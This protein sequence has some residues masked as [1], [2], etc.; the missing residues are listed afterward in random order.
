MEKPIVFTLL[1]A[2]CSIGSLSAQQDTVITLQPGPSNGQDVPLFEHSPN[3]N[4]DQSPEFIS[5]HWNFNN[6]ISSGVSL[7]KFNM[8]VLPIG[9]E[10][11]SAYLSL[12]HNPTSG[13][14]GQIGDNA[15]YLKKVTSSWKSDEVSWN[16]QPS[17]TTTNQIYLE[18]STTSTQDYFNI[19]VLNFV[20]DWQADTS[21]NY[22]MMLEIIERTKSAQSMKFCS[23]NFTQAAKRPKLVITYSKKADSDTCLS[24]QP[25]A[26]TGKDVLLSENYPNSAIYKTQEFISYNWTFSG[27]YRRG[28]S[29]V[30]FDLPQLS[31]NYQLVDARLSLYHNPVSSSAGHSGNNASYLKKVTSMWDET[32][33]TWNNMPSTT[34][35]GKILL[36]SS[37][38]NNQNYTGINLTEMA[39]SWYNNPSTNYGMMLEVIEQSNNL[40]SM[41][42]CSS[43]YAD[44]TLSPKLELCFA[45][46]SNLPETVSESHAQL[47]PNPSSG[48]FN[49]VLNATQRQVP[50]ATIRVFNS[51]GQLVYHTSHATEGPIA[52]KLENAVPGVYFVQ[53]TTGTVVTAQTITVQ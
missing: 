28:Y 19:D 4:P 6:G 26:A 47:F 48:S 25:G 7:L 32:T 10:A 11:T 39:K 30:Q 17:S 33:A 31:G 21:K 9:Y 23:S 20:T 15:C 12:Y 45:L 50:T 51:Q 29:L 27:N 52:V 53:T 41:K 2:L 24:L 1:L 8:P 42:F 37:N 22:G 40:N 43:N 13:S 49:L 35:N 46:V 18:K 36:D 3:S 16:S 34:E 14:A 44:S 38:S 5:Y